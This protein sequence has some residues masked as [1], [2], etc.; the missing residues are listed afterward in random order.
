MNAVR[1]KEKER[2]EKGEEDKNKQDRSLE[3]K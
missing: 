1:K 3:K 2:L